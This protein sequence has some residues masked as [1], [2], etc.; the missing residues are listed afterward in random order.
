[1]NEPTPGPGDNRPSDRI[2]PTTHALRGQL[3]SEETDEL[4]GSA[5]EDD[6]WRCTFCGWVDPPSLFDY[7]TP[8]GA[9]L[10]SQCAQAVVGDTYLPDDYCSGEG[11]YGSGHLRVR[12]NTIKAPGGT[13]YQP[14]PNQPRTWWA[15]KP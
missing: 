14:R 8:Y 13:V 4:L 11:N 5:N 9:P 2:N 12:S 10:C 6:N 1:M 15:P 3:N 7:L